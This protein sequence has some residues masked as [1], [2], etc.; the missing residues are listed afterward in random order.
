MQGK[1][2]TAATLLAA[3]LTIGAC[4]SQSHEGQSSAAP[5]SSPAAAMSAAST[6]MQSVAR[7]GAFH[8]L[9]S[10]TVAGT[11][12]VTG[13]TVGLEGFSSDAGPDLHVYLTNGTDENAVAAGKQLG[14]VAFDQASQSFSVSGID[15]SQYHNVVI[16]CDKAKAVFGSA[17][18]M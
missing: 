11:A 12:R 8:G 5:S 9:N 13:G 1:V 10:K 14:P 16:H 17:A 6:A 15:T 7:T 4:S 18:L 2:F 3:T